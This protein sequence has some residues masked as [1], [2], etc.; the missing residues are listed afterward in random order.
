MKDHWHIVQIMSNVIDLA[1]MKNN[2]ISL[3][4]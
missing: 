4:E 3:K 1:V 2:A